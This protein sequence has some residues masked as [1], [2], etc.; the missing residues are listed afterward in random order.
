MI[1]NLGDEVRLDANA[2]QALANKSILAEIIHELIP[3]FEN[4]PVQNVPAYISTQPEIGRRPVHLG[5]TNTGYIRPLE[6]ENAIKGEGKAVFDVFF[7]LNVPGSNGECAEVYVNVEAQASEYKTYTMEQRAVYYMARLISSQYERDFSNSHYEK[8]KK[9]YSIWLIFDPQKQYRNSIS[10]FSY[11]QKTILGTPKDD[12]SYDLAQA[13]FVRLSDDVLYK[14]SKMIG[15]LNTLFS[16]QVSKQDKK[17]ILS[18]EYG[19]KVD[20]DLERSVDEMC[21]Y[22]VSVLNKGLAEGRVRTIAELY[23][24]G[25][26]SKDKALEKIQ[27][28]EQEFDEI[29]ALLFGAGE[30]DNV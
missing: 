11:Q 21:N 15:V 17:T 10:T 23:V 25:D 9:V 14:N 30:E 22:S 26:I 8:L 20:K 6:Q 16:K 2:K 29:V 5:E 19:V 4:I 24:S 27:M 18:Q 1:D 3:G 12:G 13:F 28:S 7:L